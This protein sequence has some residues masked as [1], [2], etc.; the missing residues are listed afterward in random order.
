MTA[1]NLSPNLSAV[2]P[3]DTQQL[4]RDLADCKKLL[5]SERQQVASL[6]AENKD[7]KQQLKQTDQ[8]KQLGIFVAIHALRESQLLREEKVDLMN[9]RL[10]AIPMDTVPN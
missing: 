1:T 10:S 9:P 3:E 6:R 8:D 5:V 4:L 7:L 2:N